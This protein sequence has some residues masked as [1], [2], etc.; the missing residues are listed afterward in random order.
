MITLPPDP[1]LDDFRAAIAL[2]DDEIDL[3]RAGLLV[4]KAEY[5]YL[6][7]EPIIESFDALASRVVI[8]AGG[9]HDPLAQVEALNS[10]V[11]ADLGLKGATESYYDPKNSFLNDI[12]ERKT[13]IPISL[14]IIY[15]SIG[16]RAG[17]A[18]GG[19]AMPMHFLVRILGLRPPKFVDCYNGG[20][21][22]GKGE[23]V[24]AVR[25]M[26]SGKIAFR[27]EMLEVISN[28]AALTRLL[29]NLK[30]IYLNS[31]QY[32]KSLPIFD[33][34]IALN[35]DENGLLRERGIARYKIGQGQL[36]RQDLQDYL[37]TAIEAPDAEE[38]R[39]L[40]RRMG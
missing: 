8:R 20:R 21:V 30:M 14:A 6:D 16:A 39:N 28:G 4:A 33:R 24:E 18:L 27:E 37:Q 19:T 32:A 12:L 1:S 10:V 38:I 22:V 17:I 26:S 40:L 11:I 7:I 25:Q 29:T 2:P 36:A 9:D 34:L 5:P 31:L 35:P 13:G 3:A 23:C 15:M